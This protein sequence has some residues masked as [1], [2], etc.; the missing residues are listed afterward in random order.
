MGCQCLNKKTED[1]EI[2]T[3]DNI[4]LNVSD[5][6]IKNEFNKLEYDNV[7]EKEN[8]NKNILQEKS[9]NLDNHLDNN[10]FDDN[11]NKFNYRVLNLINKIR[12]DPPSYANTIL[13]NIKNITQENNKLIFKRKV[14]VLLNKGESEFQKAAEILKKTS[15]MNE[16]EV[17]KEIE[18]RL[19]LSKEEVY[20]DLLLINQ[21]NIIRQNYNINVYFKNMIKN[22]EIAVLM[23]IVDDSLENPGMRRNAI[24]NP[25]F[26]KIGISSKFIDNI[27][28]SFFSFSK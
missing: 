15:P 3:E 23:L 21:V 10:I 7:L 24:L 18:I 2:K 26:R 25:K 1:L 20:D 22:P 11:I 6:A 4:D 8:N 19:P 9:T 16:L 5:P 17:K 13:E 27:F 28:I 12:K 14:K